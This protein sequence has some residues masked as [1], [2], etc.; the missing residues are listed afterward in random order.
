MKKI[1]WIF[2]MLAMQVLSTTAFAE[3]PEALKGTWAVDAKAT[4]AFL[5][6][7]PPANAERWLPKVTSDM[8]QRIY[9]FD[10]GVITASTYLGDKKSIYR[11]LSQQSDNKKYISE[12]GG[13]D[14]VLIV[15]IVN[16][17]NIVIS[18][19]RNQFIGGFFWKRAKLNPD[20]REQ[21]GK[22]AAEASKIA[23]K[24][25]MQILNP[26]PDPAGNTDTTR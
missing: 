21:D 15:T 6:K 14:D 25:F 16:E 20:A 3:M 9:D 13:R 22:L 1:T 7:F 2:L 19:S 18:S 10:N 26:T 17:S 8:F 4:E 11:P 24:D 12:E 23:I 5:K